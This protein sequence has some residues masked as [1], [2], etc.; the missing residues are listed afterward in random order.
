MTE[1]TNEGKSQTAKILKWMLSGR[2][3]TALEALKRFNCFRLASRINNIRN[4][5]R[6]KI[7]TEMVKTKTSHK[8]IAR[9]SINL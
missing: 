2:S 3:I 6:Y 5:N 9:Y 8:K 1:P 4:M 7:V